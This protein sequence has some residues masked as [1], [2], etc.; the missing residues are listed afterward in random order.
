V[1]VRASLRLLDTGA[2]Y[3]LD[4]RAAD[5]MGKPNLEGDL[6]ARLPI[7]GLWQA[8]PRAS[9]PGRRKI[10][11]EEEHK[12]DSDD[13]AFDLKAS[14]KADG[15]GAQLSDLSLT[16]EQGGRPQIVT[17]SV[18]SSWSGDFGLDMNLASRWLDLDRI[19][20]ATEQSGPVESIAKFA[21]RL[22]DFIP[23]R[24][25]AQVSLAVDQAS[26]GGDGVGPVRLLLKRTD[27]KLDI[28]DLR[29]ALPG[30]S[31]AELQ[32]TI[33]DTAQ[34]VVF[35]GRLALRGA[36]VTRFLTWATGDALP[37]DARA[38]G[39]FGLRAQITAGNGMVAA[40]DV[41]ATLSGTTL[42]GTAQY[43]W[44]GRPELVVALDGP[45]IDGR[46]FLPA[47]ASLAG[48]YE[49]LLRSSE[50]PHPGAQPEGAKPGWPGIQTDISLRINAGQLATT[51]RVYRDVAAAIE[52]KGGHLRQ[53]Q[54]RLSGDEGY[55]LE[56]DGSIDDVGTLPK[57]SV[58]GAAKA[59]T[60]AAVAPLSELIGVPAAW[61]AGEGREQVLVPLRLAGSMTFGG[62]TATS[63]DLVIDG[64]AG[65]AAVRLNAR[66]DGGPG[67]WRA[68]RAD[69]T[70]T[71]ASANGAAVARLF[72]PG[73]TPTGSAGRLLVKATGVPNEGMTT[74]ASFD[75]GDLALSFRGKSTL[76]AAGTITSG[77][78]EFSTGDTAPL[79]ALAG[80]SPPLRADGVPSRGRLHLT[81]GDTKTLVEKLVGNVGGSRL[82]GSFALSQAGERPRIDATLDTD[83]VSVAKLLAP[84]LDQQL[85]VAGM[86][87]AA[88]SG[89]QGV[90]PHEPFNGAAF[91]AIEGRVQLSCRRLT[92]G[93]GLALDGAQL[94]IGFG[95]GR[96]DVAEI[97]GRG[98]GGELKAKLQI[99]KAG[100]GA[101]ARG[102]LSFSGTLEALAD[103]KAP[104]ASGPVSGSLDFAGHGPTP[105]SLVAALQ[106]QGK[107]N[108]GEARLDA[109]WPGA[110]PLAADS[111]LR[112]EPD[113]MAAAIRRGLAAG[114]ST[115]HL[116]LGQETLVL[117]LADGHLRVK[118]FAV[119]T[120]EG[121]T[122]GVASL[123]LR[124]LAFDSQ[125]RLEAKSGI[126]G[127][128]GKPLPAVTVVYSG[129][130]AALGTI[131]PRIDSTAL[132]QELSARKIEREVEELERLRRLDEQRRQ[133]ESERLRKQFEQQPPVQNPS[134]PS[135]VPVAPSSREIRPAAP[136]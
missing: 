78:L 28:Q 85:A 4:A 49:F 1:R 116:P 126:S 109:L 58:R 111:A 10:G 104:R 108:F 120:R 43:R 53:L 88:I 17:G 40:R 44:D 3:L 94:D 68:G 132:E 73:H 33:F 123:D 6:T 59:R 90:W 117:E 57:G 66:F 22:R 83:D 121:R 95:N 15:A 41:V 37:I 42:S 110:I 8:L 128:G 127:A 113:K 61:R 133:M 2:T 50:A 86:A 48:M 114:L 45:Q 38:D 93:E 25:K 51:G 135:S 84:L 29:V 107:I 105:R 81:I 52:L 124:S 106:G 20:G 134:L 96:I 130:V 101:E 115:G 39:A 5:L 14:V 19:T 97:S 67:G 119:D 55:Q 79:L 31:R 131:E 77:E 102:S 75:A 136:G 74:L 30:G 7:A 56:L 9:A 76:A 69:I 64:S 112:A 54:L 46:S 18:R 60:H 32:G 62:R 98:L 72:L 21:G 129:P 99:A 36:S 47:G 27:E 92:L 91:D 118:P 103:S 70:A 100:A 23:G 89:R 12:L 122:N 87:E 35:N 13:A 11:A 125:W 24:G 65:D 26:L 34:A 71:A 63:A 80:L 82:S 16:F